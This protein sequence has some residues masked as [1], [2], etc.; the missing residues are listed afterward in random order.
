ML[1]ERVVP[2]PLIAPHR[3]SDAQMAVSM[4]VGRGP[5]ARLVADAATLVASDRVV[6]IGC[7][8][9]TATSRRSL[10]GSRSCGCEGGNTCE[11]GLRPGVTGPAARTGGHDTDR[12]G[13]PRCQR[14]DRAGGGPGR[15]RGRPAIRFANRMEDGQDGLDK[16]DGPQEPVA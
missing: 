15:D 6:D 16:S 4:A 8:P 12:S 11:P 14:R 3:I 9:G 7:G 2:L 10:V 5:A 1:L 13:S